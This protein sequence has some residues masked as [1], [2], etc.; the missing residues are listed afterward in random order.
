MTSY[1]ALGN[2]E[3]DNGVHGLAAYL[4]NL[5]VPVLSANLDVSREPALQGQFNASRV[6]EVG[7]VKVGIIGVITKD[8]AFISNAG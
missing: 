5:T 4:R 7:G 6:M 8:T 1:Q 2:H 3:F